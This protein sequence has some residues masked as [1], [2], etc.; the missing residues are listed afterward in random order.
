[1]MFNYKPM[2][3]IMKKHFY[4]AFLSAIVLIGSSIFVSCSSADEPLAQTEEN[5]P[6]SEKYN[7]ATGEVGVEF[8]MNVSSGSGN[9][10]QTSA[11][12]QASIAENFRGINNALLATFK[13]A[14]DGKIISTAATSDKTYNMGEILGSGALDP[15]GSGSTPKSRRVIELALPTGTNTLMFW[16]KAIKNGTDKAQGSI[17]YTANK[18]LSTTSFTL[19]KR[20]PESSVA[21][22]TQYKNLLAAVMTKL[23]DSRVDV[24]GSYE[25]DDFNVNFGWKDYVTYDAGKLVRQTNTPAKEAGDPDVPMENDA[26]GEIM[27]D[28]FISLNTIY[29]NELRA[30]AGPA[31]SRMLGDLYEVI[32]S[33]ALA[34]PTSKSEA[35][36]KALAAQIKSWLTTLIDTSAKTWNA[37]ASVKSWVGGSY[38]LAT[39]D[40]NTFPVTLFN[41][42]QGATILQ[43]A[44]GNPT[45]DADRT[46]TYSYKETIPD[47]AMSGGPGGSF[48]PL[49]YRYPAELCYFG[50]SPVRVTNDP[51]VTAD[52]PDGVTD[53]DNDANAKW[54]GWTKNGHVLSSTRSVAM[55]QNINYG[56]A[57]L[58][59]TVRYGAATLQDN[60]YNIQHDRKGAN[61]PNNTIPA[62]AGTFTLTGVLIGGVE[63]EMGWNYL[64]KA[65]TP[66]FTSYIY[67]NDLPS[68][69]IPAY[70]A[71][72]GAKSTPNYTLVWDNWNQANLGNKQNV[73]YIALEFVNNS[74]VDFW[75]LNNL[76]R[77]GATFYITGKLDPDVATAEKLAALGKTAEQY[78]A[79][80]S[81]GITWPEKYALP[82]YAADGST[83]QQRRVFI[84]DYMTQ[85]NFTLGATSLQSALIAVP[86]LR[87]TQ[88]SLGLS[89]DLEWQGGLVFEST[90]GQ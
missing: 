9:T 90:L 79:D 40:L 11:N 24:T 45:V 49:N 82:P 86:D 83:I 71:G 21:A 73:V 33:V 25:S 8:V 44:I 18:D 63:P 1:M 43:I 42:P 59:T 36:T 67:D 10:R 7:P 19:N 53:W 27:A 39:G 48:D 28:A 89:V 76:I 23:V 47:Y 72:D 4:L 34:T 2:R 20:I 51:H 52:Y 65:A 54:T 61:E 57:L 88:I 35:I 14:E 77:N 78:A 46:F 66:T 15:D 70:E 31:V 64:A 32:N 55:Q 12:T 5:A 13:Q 37:T 85:A 81:L 30:G 60:N 80:K 16:G 74:G 3:K 84:Q 58:K 17:S 75:G 6:A 50:N 68:T 26:L 38:D 62:A 41:V 56:T 29:T 69:A 22:F 87:S